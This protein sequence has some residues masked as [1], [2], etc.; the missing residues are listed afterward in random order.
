M[1]TV[2]STSLLNVLQSAIDE[3]IGLAAKRYFH[4][5][6]M[7]AAACDEDV[8]GTRLSACWVGSQSTGT[9]QQRFHGLADRRVLVAGIVPSSMRVSQIGDAASGCFD[10][11]HLPSLG[12]EVGSAK[13]LS[14]VHSPGN[15]ASATLTVYGRSGRDL[16]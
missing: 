15:R 6:G 1:G 9:K 2:R 5:R 4:S 3:R 14:E 11:A 10:H 16:D 12:S 13:L 7:S 8:L